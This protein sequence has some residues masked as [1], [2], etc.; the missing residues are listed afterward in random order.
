MTALHQN[1]FAILAANPRDNRRRI[2]ELAEVRSLELD[3]ELCQKA[4]ADLT[5]PRTRL[6]VEIAWLPGVSPRKAIALTEAILKDPMAIREESGLPSLAHANLMAAAFEAVDASDTAE[7]VAEFILEIAY[8]V[9]EISVD[10]VMRDINEDR[11][12]SNFPEVKALG[13]V[14]AEI[15]ERKRCFRNAIRAALNRLPPA[16]LVDAMTQAVYLATR[17]G[18]THAP[19]LVDDLVDSYAMETQALLQKEGENAEKLIKAAR[20][21]AKAGETTVKPLIKKLEI[22]VRNWGKITRPIRLS[23]KARGITHDQSRDFAFA[24]RSL[25]IDLFNNHDMLGQS[26]RLNR[27]VKTVFSDLPD[28]LEQVSEDATTLS[29][30]K[31]KRDNEEKAHEVELACGLNTNLPGQ[32]RFVAHIV[33]GHVLPS[34][35]E[36]EGANWKINHKGAQK[37]EQFMAVRSVESIRFGVEV[38]LLTPKDPAWTSGKYNREHYYFLSLKS[39]SD[40]EITYTHK[41]NPFHDQPSKIQGYQENFDL[42]LTAAIHYFLP[43]IVKKI[44]QRLSQGQSVKIGG[45]TLTSNGIQFETTGWF[46]SKTHILPWSNVSAGVL[47]GEV[48]VSERSTPKNKIILPLLLTDNALAIAAL[49]ESH[50][51]F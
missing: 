25:S 48:V 32:I 12:V 2:V 22:A 51:K 33:R 21:G 41:S 28:V 27:L 9:D 6:G 4:S 15:A 5:N 11:A 38:K 42:F 10:D 23:A 3:H 35:L 24:I 30:I 13:P 36:G 40:A 1:P 26:T 37:G 43:T 44:D 7:D 46:S 17:G 14:E 50:N 39:D 31:I 18:K 49:V 19:E 45:C 34:R 29:N 8:L 20:D 16:S 47:N